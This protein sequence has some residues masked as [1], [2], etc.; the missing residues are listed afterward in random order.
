MSFDIACK[1][2]LYDCNYFVFPIMSAEIFAER[3]TAFN[4]QNTCNTGL[5][6]TISNDIGTLMQIIATKQCWF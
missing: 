1:A 3:I 6:A 5:K 4:G 2:K